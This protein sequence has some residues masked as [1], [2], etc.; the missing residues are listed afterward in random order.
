MPTHLF[1]LHILFVLYS[2]IFLFIIVTWQKK[3]FYFIYLPFR[4]IFKHFDFLLFFSF[5]F[6]L[7]LFLQ[8]IFSLFIQ[9]F[10]LSNFLCFVLLPEIQFYCYLTSLEF[11]LFFFN[12]LSGTGNSEKS[13]REKKWFPMF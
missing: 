8:F 12:Y 11:K 10:I 7:V 4:N 13:E 9:N 1:L 3:S 5:F 6:S 2:L